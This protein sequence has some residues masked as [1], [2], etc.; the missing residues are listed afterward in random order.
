[1]RSE[2][3]R[4]RMRTPA[5][6]DGERVYDARVFKGKIGFAAIELGYMSARNVD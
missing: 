3:F 5:V 2:D 6:V 4:E 1:M